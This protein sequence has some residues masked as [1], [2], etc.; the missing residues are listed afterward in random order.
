[1][2]QLRIGL[3]CILTGILLARI[4]VYLS[5]PTPAVLPAQ[6]WYRMS[7][8]LQALVF[9]SFC[10]FVYGCWKILKAIV[11]RGDRRRV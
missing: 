6:I 10:L 1:M 8:G 3:A 5:H 2:S 9:A 11:R 4:A 7:G